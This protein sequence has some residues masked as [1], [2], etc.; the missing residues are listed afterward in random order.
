LS[1]PG[2]P[3]DALS[4]VV[5]AHQSAARIGDLLLALGEQLDDDDELVVVDNLSTDGTPQLV[6]TVAP[7]A[8]LLEPGENLGFACGCIAGAS[9]TH[10]PLLLFVNPDCR[11]WPGCLDELRHAGAEHPEWAAWQAMVLLDEDH[12][13][14]SGGL[15]HYLG[16]GW[17]GECGRRL[18]ESPQQQ[19]EITFPSGAAMVMRRNAWEAI[20]GFD[21]TYF[22]YGEDL[23][24][25][26]RLWLT[27]QCVGLLPSA[28]VSHGYEFD[29]GGAKWFLLERN[30][31]RTVLSLYPASLLAL[32]APALL[33][34][35]IVLLAVSARQGWLEAKLRADIAVIRGLPS[36][37]ARRRAW[38][39]RRKIS[40]YEF[41]GH[42]TAS[43]AS[44]YLAGAG[45]FLGGLQAIY[46]R[47]VLRTLSLLGR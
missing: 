35:E 21:P 41:A 43:L 14:T 40:A 22:M 37:L 20:G 29:K 10:A 2:I 16:F 46:W 27:G 1:S 34:F 18:L 9:V 32:V 6:Q 36:S 47:T 4:V 7:R 30:R 17:A 23:D 26:L 38:Q 8:R 5:V 24:L 25:G 13:N 3:H 45:S 11:P 31:W 44:P 33:A 28:R 42:L 15:V 12:I 39:A 19:R